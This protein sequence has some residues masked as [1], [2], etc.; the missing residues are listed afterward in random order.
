MVLAKLDELLARLN[1]ESA[2]RAV[3]RLRA[4]KYASAGVLR[5][6]DRL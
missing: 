3:F 2:V 1:A 5:R 6:D 4:A